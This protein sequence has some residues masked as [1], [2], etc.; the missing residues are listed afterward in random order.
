M[1]RARAFIILA[2][3]SK[4]VEIAES[5]PVTQLTFVHTLFW[6]LSFLLNQLHFLRT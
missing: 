3:E 4:L 2:I 1:R 6:Q 5:L